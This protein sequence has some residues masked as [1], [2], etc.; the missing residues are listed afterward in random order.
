MEGKDGLVVS[1]QCRLSC[2]ICFKLAL[3]AHNIDDVFLN[4]LAALATSRRDVNVGVL[5]L[6]IIMLK[7]KQWKMNDKPVVQSTLIPVSH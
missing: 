3:C 2:K 1:F 5:A 6:I 4:G 7:V